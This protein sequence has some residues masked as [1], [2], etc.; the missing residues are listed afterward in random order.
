[1]P[2]NSSVD[3]YLTPYSTLKELC[4][5]LT[6]YL[7]VLYDFHYKQRLPPYNINWLSL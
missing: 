6:V 4:I 3:S 7:C 5:L 2:E 1:M